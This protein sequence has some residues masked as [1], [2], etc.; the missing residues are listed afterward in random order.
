MNDLVL[1]VSADCRLCER[2]RSLLE[3]VGVPFREVDLA[4]DEAEELAHAG[5]PVFF[6]P[7]LV[8]DRRVIAYGDFNEDEL[9]RGLAVGAA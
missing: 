6:F 1:V 3:S 2:A 5:V 4:D 9:R 8:A 7:V